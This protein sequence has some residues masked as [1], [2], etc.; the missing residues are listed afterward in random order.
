MAEATL[1]I[2][3]DEQAR[4]VE[5]DPRGMIIGRHPDCEILLESGRVSRR[6]ARIYRD[7]FNRWVI[8]DLQSKHGVW[9]GQQRI[10]AGAILPG[11][12]FMVGPFTLTLAE[13]A[14]RRIAPDPAATSAST[15]LE[16]DSGAEIIPADEAQSFLGHAQ[17]KRLNEIA[18]L[19]S[20]L[21]S[22][23][24]LYAKVCEEL[25]GPAGGMAAVLRLP[26][27]IHDFTEPPETLAS[28]FGGQRESLDLSSRSNLHLSRSVLN[29][30]R[31][32]GRSVMAGS[33][34][35]SNTDL[36][37]TIVDQNRPRVVLCAPITEPGE[38]V[39]VLY[40]DVPSDRAGETTLDFIQAVA[41]Q[42]NLAGRS[43]LFAE[44]RAERRVLDQQLQ[45][46]RRIQS[47]LIPTGVGPVPGLDLAH[48]YRPA[49]WVG[50]DYCDTWLLADG[51]LAFAIG[52]VCGKGLPAAMLMSSLQAALRSTAAFC[53][54]PAEITAHVN[55][56][57][58]LSLLETMFVTLF[59]GVFDPQTGRLEYVNA[60]HL[61]PII[62]RPDG[63][64]R[65]GRP[66]NQPIGVHEGAFAGQDETITPGT[67]LVVYTD[68][69]T[70]AAAPSGEMLGIEGVL[71]VLASAPC[72][73]A[74]RMVDAV[75]DAAEKYRCSLPPQDDIT[76]FALF[77]RDPARET[78]K[79]V[80]GLNEEPTF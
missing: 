32:K 9:R 61:P 8:E 21:T 55:T 65:L 80:M 51:R 41:R 43:L 19:V 77:Y 46:A 29:A 56:Q 44:D 1:T 16:D 5:L 27:P 79:T 64:E 48:C 39:D 38:T 76:V 68:G 23:G 12:R 45:L 54:N 7:P 31:L 73:S 66:A 25:A 69:I 11:E 47:N 63:A 49:M 34:R 42:V 50:G 20:S 72:S 62:R 4:T 57:M 52:D 36:S 18:D 70:E 78:P 15:I 22:P 2:S 10:E 24:D 3:R 71:E 30:V 40:L 13:S 28:R 74:A 58:T 33:T 60:G 35:Q 6:H 59:L 37:L 14:K 17:I 53:R 67:G 75:T 26:G